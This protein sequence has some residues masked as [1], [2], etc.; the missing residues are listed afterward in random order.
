MCFMWQ[1]IARFV[2]GHV[3]ILYYLFTDVFNY[4]SFKLTFFKNVRTHYHNS[5]YYTLSEQQPV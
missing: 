4:V 3:I 5:E 2:T 1:V